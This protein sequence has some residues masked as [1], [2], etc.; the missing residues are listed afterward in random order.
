MMQTAW[1][2]GYETFHNQASTL[3]AYALEG[4]LDRL[5]QYLPKTLSLTRRDL[6]RVVR[7]YCSFQLASAVVAP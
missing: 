1:L 2:Q 5:R 6:Q 7:H 4:H 3:G